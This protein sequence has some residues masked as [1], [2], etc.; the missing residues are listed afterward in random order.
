MGRIEWAAPLPWQP[1]LAPF[2]QDYSTA[3][4]KL[5][6]HHRWINKSIRWR[7]PASPLCWNTE[8][9][10]TENSSANDD[11]MRKIM[12]ITD[13]LLQKLPEDVIHASGKTGFGVGN[14]IQAI[15]DRVPAPKGDP[16]APLQALI[17][18]SVYNSYR[19][20][21]ISF[22]GVSIFLANTIESIWA[23]HR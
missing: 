3:L 7:A 4:R 19:G 8:R 6:N 23:R 20:I 12:E 15:I 13:E 14:I 21:D 9:K 5:A 16:D 1:P 10:N 11:E 17:F 22:V 2:S 18:D